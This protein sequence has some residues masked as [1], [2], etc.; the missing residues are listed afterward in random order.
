MS[1]FGPIDFTIRKA[2]EPV[3]LTVPGGCGSHWSA[4]IKAS[5]DVSVLVSVR[6]E[7][8]L[9]VLGGVDVAGGELAR[10]DDLLPVN[11]GVTK[12]GK[13]RFAITGKAGTTGRLAGG[14]VAEPGQ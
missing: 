7:V 5:S 9:E 2:D 13:L 6:D 14:F 4:R 12:N 10:L 8:G 11:L 1:S 3:V